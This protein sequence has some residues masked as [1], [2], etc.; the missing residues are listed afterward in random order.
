IFSLKEK[1]KQN[2]SI[3]INIID[4]NL[5]KENEIDEVIYSIKPELIVKACDPAGIFLTNLNKVCFNYKI[6]Y[7][8]MAYS[9][10]LLKIGPLIVPNIT[11]CSESLSKNAVE[12]Y[13]EHYKV[14]NFEKIFNNYLFHPSISFNIN[15]LSSIIFKE[16]LFFL[17]GE[18]NYCQT[19]GR[20]ITF[21]P[22]SFSTNSYL[23]KCDD[24]CKL[25]FY[26]GKTI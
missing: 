5:T 2:F 12:H 20:I 16:I 7:I 19:I 9:Y 15:I 3:N 22:L 17:I 23:I 14:E 24:N 18:Y 8:S 1:I 26:E 21:N 11:S 10:E 6:P 4:A 13:G 25:C